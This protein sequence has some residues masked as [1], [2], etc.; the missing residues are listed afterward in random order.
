MTMNRWLLFTLL[1]AGVLLT[2]L[3]HS[4]PPNPFDIS[5]QGAMLC[6]LEGF[7]CCTPPAGVANPDGT[8]L[9]NCGHGLGCDLATATC[10]AACGGPGQACCD[11]PETRAPRWTGDG[12]LYVP[13]GALVQEMCRNSVCNTTTRLCEGNC[14]RNAGD[15]CC[16]PQPG[17]AVATCLNPQLACAFA[18]GS[19]YSRGSCQPCGGMG[20]LAC[21]HAEKCSPGM[22]ELADGTCGCG[23]AATAGADSPVLDASACPHWPNR[24]VMCFE[25]PVGLVHKINGSTVAPPMAYTKVCVEGAFQIRD[26]VILTD[27]D[28]PRI[29]DGAQI[30][31]Q[32]TSAGVMYRKRDETIEFTQGDGTSA[33]GGSRFAF[34]TSGTNAS[35]NATLTRI[36]TTLGTWDVPWTDS[37]IDLVTIGARVGHRP[38]DVELRVL[39]PDLVPSTT[40]R[41]KL[42]LNPDV[43]LVPV[44]VYA[45]H[46]DMAAAASAF[47]REKALMVFDRGA[48]L[49]EGKTRITDAVTRQLTSSMQTLPYL[50][51]GGGAEP[52]NADGHDLPDDI[53]AQC[54]IQFRLVNYVPLQVPQVVAYPPTGTHQTIQGAARA[55]LAAA[56]A[57]P[58]FIENVLTV[59]VAPWCADINQGLGGGFEIPEGQTLIGSNAVC[60]RYSASGTTIAHEL[61]HSLMSSDAHPC[62]PNGLMCPA[63]GGTSL[64]REQCAAARNSLRNSSRLNFPTQ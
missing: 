18:P 38:M 40:Q 46:T 37:M 52:A 15:A 41:F 63:A 50:V 45:L 17:I 19:Q 55:M 60:V 23:S 47:S 6:G 2:P 30:S 28:N 35:I 57:H 11:G 62:P 43:M 49:E 3:S 5:R 64:T 42:A 16:A 34:D 26:G 54:G 51:T 22:E 29:W 20:Q 21:T 48:D 39:G 33:R 31:G 61:G 1:L 4:Q 13:T 8:P 9:V 12:R 24:R 32:R 59:M 53:W 36:P 58:T 14:G 27:V 44:Q 10:V 56:R 25:K 7:G